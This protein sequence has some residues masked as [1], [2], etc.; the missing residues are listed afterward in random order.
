MLGVKVRAR[1]RSAVLAAATPPS[2]RSQEAI[3]HQLYDTQTYPA[4]GI[5]TLSFGLVNADKTLSNFEANNQLPAPKSMQL[6]NICCDIFPSAAG[7]SN[8]LAATAAGNL[9]DMQKI[10][11]QARGTWTLGISDK[12]YG[13]YS[14]TDLH[15]TGGPQGF[16]VGTGAAAD[17]LQHARNEVSPGWNYCGSIIIPE[18]TTF[19]VT[20]NFQ[21][22]LVPIAVDHLIRIS[23]FGIQQRRVL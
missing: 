2:G 12:N 1:P 19:T 22:T 14:L 13:P 17:F 10:L 18:Q 20:L 5:V 8:N 9:N 4:A 16:M 6:Y 15:G 7:V 21:A 23:L 3:W 11:F